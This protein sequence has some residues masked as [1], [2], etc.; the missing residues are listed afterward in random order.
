MHPLLQEACRT[1]RR[2]NLRTC[3]LLSVQL[4]RECNEMGCKCSEN[5]FYTT[6]RMELYEG[7]NRQIRKMCEQCE[8][9]ISRLKRVAIGDITLEGLPNGKWK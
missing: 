2:D 9:E 6:V 8:L 3:D 1:P 7:R 5:S 4:L